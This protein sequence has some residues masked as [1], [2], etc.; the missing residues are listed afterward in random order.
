MAGLEETPVRCTARRSLVAAGFVLFAAWPLP[1]KEVAWRLSATEKTKLVYEDGQKKF[2]WPWSRNDP[3]TISPFSAEEKRW[4]SAVHP[5]ASFRLLKNGDDGVPDEYL[6][7]EDGRVVAKDDFFPVP[8][9]GDDAQALILLVRP[10][11]GLL[12]ADG[13]SELG[14]R[15][16]AGE[17]PGET[18]TE[19]TWKGEPDLDELLYRDDP[20]EAEGPDD[21]VEELP[22]D[23]PDP[24]P[25][26]PP[27]AREPVDRAALAGEVHFLVVK[28]TPSGGGKVLFRSRTAPPLV[29]VDVTRIRSFTLG[30]GRGF[31]IVYRWPGATPEHVHVGYALYARGPWGVTEAWKATVLDWG[32]EPMDR[33]ATSFQFARTTPTEG[34]EQEP[35][36]LVRRVSLA[37]AV[38]SPDP[39]RYLPQIGGAE[40]PDA[41]RGV[42]DIHRL[43]GGIFRMVGRADRARGDLPVA[44]RKNWP[45]Y[46]ARSSRG[47]SLLLS[48][49]NPGSPFGAYPC[50]WPG[51]AAGETPWI[52][53]DSIY[54]GK[55]H[56]K[57]DGDLAMAA[58]MLHDPQALYLMVVIRDDALVLPRIDD[59]P[60]RGDHLQLWLD[61]AYGEESL[62][63]E[64]LPGSPPGA[65]AF[66]RVRSP[67]SKVGPATRIRVAARPFESGYW[68]EAAIPY[69]YLGDVDLRPAGSLWG[70]A[71][72]AVD[73]DDAANPDR[74]TVLSTSRAFQ[75]AKTSTFNNLILE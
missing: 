56:L 69:A 50:P 35:E 26:P 32:A 3:N 13:R 60:A 48:F 57:G 53:R 22:P 73:V 30:A 36:L 16:P 40:T 70:F 25:P 75:W 43:R 11:D 12:S 67:S 71:V 28:P 1:G 64:L 54:K 58:W 47:P 5:S 45:D 62:M 39:D 24:S 34:A 37:T 51:H 68:L 29:G 23:P 61:P 52:E 4:L 20:P 49:G 18:G 33:F 15:A 14:G 31:G 9:G 27:R 17:A 21:T 8:A 42:V 72:N 46:L 59:D 6:V 74:K 7:L 38:G 2:N 65:G 55:E 19:A 41:G 44:L 63:L 66:A 10:A